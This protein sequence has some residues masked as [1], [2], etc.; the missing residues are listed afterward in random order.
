MATL[1]HAPTTTPLQLQHQH[2]ASGHHLQ[3]LPPRQLLREAAR[4]ALHRPCGVE[5]ATGAHSASVQQLCVP[6]PALRGLELRPQ[7]HPNTLPCSPFRGTAMASQSPWRWLTWAPEEKGGAGSGPADPDWTQQAAV[8][9][10]ASGATWVTA[11]H[12]HCS[13]TQ[14]PVL[15]QPGP[16]MRAARK[17]VQKGLLGRLGPRAERLGERHWSQ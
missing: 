8:D 15:L 2:H 4:A 6:P 9:W 12:A 11:C 7:N 10:L 14:P 3:L 1:T 16:R 5:A 17:A 13:C